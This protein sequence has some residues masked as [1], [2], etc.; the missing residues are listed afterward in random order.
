[1]RLFR[2]VNLSGRSKSPPF[3]PFDDPAPLD[4]LRAWGFNVL[5]LLVIWEALEP[6]RGR[7]DESYLAAV[8]R[9]VDAAE[10]R[11]LYVIVDMHQ[12]LYA[13]ALGGDGAPPWATR[14]DGPP[15]SGPRWFM[16]YL[17]SSAVQANFADF[18]RDE[19]GLRTAYLETMARLVTWMN[20]HPNVIGYDF[21]NEP[22]APMVDVVSGRFESED[23]RDF[24]AECA[25][26]LERAEGPARLQFIEPC[27]LVA[28]GVPS[29]LVHELGPTAVF[30]PHIY[31][32]GALGIRRYHPRVSTYPLAL[33]TVTDWASAHDMPLLIGEFGALNGIARAREMLEDECRMLDRVFASWTA[34]HYDVVGP[35]WNDEDASIVMVG[36]AEREFT[37]SLI[38]P[39]PRAIAGT[40]TRWES[41]R[42]RTWTFEYDAS[43]E[44]PTELVVP[45]R[46]G[47]KRPT[48]GVDGAEARWSEDEGDLGVLLL[49][50]QAGAHVVVTLTEH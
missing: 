29:R 25:R 24:N 32:I 28:F 11:G 33:E 3:L 10:Q 1:M 17:R 26:V 12:D 38:R 5:R 50:A 21:F 36:G 14:H 42:G 34:W 49:E 16:H 2:G 13:R 45:Q 23:L 47:G 30:A 22:M 4:Q 8:S 18:W 9:V 35:E 27:P 7:V 40:P 39:Y 15:A 37:I 48:F 31:D 43:G 46:W 41:K 19:D 20:G 44:G 6:E